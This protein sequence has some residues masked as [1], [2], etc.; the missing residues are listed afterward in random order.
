[1]YEALV[2]ARGIENQ[3]ATASYRDAGELWVGELAMWHRDAAR[4]PSSPHNE[5]ATHWAMAARQTHSGLCEGRDDQ[6]A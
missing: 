2:V 1:M 5:E 4:C 3:G 6:L